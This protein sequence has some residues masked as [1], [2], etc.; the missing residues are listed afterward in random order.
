MAR[1][2]SS[3]CATRTRLHWVKYAGAAMRSRSVSQRVEPTLEGDRTMRMKVLKYVQGAAVA[4]ASV[5]MAINGCAAAKD[6]EKGCDALD[7]T[8]SAQAAVRAFADAATNLQIRAEAVEAKFLAVCNAMNKD[9][10]LDSS[11]TTAAEAC[12]ILKA[13]IDQAGQAGVTVNAQ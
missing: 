13:R 4:V 8:V 5:A 6:L 11:K 7:V 10:H 1:R 3:Y 9:L 12:G 2:T